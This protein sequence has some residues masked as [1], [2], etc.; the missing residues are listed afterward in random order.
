MVT[1]TSEVCVAVAPSACNI[2]KRVVCS[3]AFHK[4]IE[5]LSAK[6]R[7]ELDKMFLVGECNWPTVLDT[8]MKS[9][10]SVPVVDTYLF[11][12]NVVM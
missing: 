1:Q 5:F 8:D 7:W 3:S 11:T 10:V 4:S 9:V 12:N 6:T 2:L